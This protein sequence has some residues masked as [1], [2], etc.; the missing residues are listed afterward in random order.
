MT[1]TVQRARAT[2][3]MCVLVG[4]NQGPTPLDVERCRA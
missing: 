1:A 2:A 4:S 3:S